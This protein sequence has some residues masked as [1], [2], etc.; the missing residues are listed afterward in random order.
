MGLFG[1]LQA[2]KQNKLD[3]KAGVMREALSEVFTD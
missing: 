1:M 2:S 3:I